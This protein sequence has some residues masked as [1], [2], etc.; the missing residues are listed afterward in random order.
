MKRFNLFMMVLVMAWGFS[1]TPQSQAADSGDLIYPRDVG[2]KARAELGYESLRRDV[3]ITSEDG[4][5]VETF[6]ADVFFLRM[7]T[8]VGPD[9]RMDFDVGLM[10]S[11]RSLRWFGGVGLRFLAYRH[12][13]FRVGTFAQVRYAPDLKGRMDLPAG[14]R[15][16]VDHDLI[17]ADA[18]ILF[19]YLL[20]LGDQLTITPYAGPVLSI[21]RLDGDFRNPEGAKEDFK[22]R[23]DNLFGGAAGLA[24]QLPGQNSI[25]FEGRYFDEWSMSVAA[26]ITF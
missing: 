6:D 10:D 18:G 15:T 2:V 23:E 1:F 4:D 22:A 9:A 3:K 12:E 8:G 19:G 26:A 14:D 20:R 21:V 7:Q 25:R 24:L 16:P 5:P 13:D 11:G 17:E